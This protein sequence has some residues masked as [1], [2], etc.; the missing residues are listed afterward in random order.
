MRA[1]QVCQ[2]CAACGPDA[3]IGECGAQQSRAA[4]N[5][6]DW[7]PP[8]PDANRCLPCRS[9]SP[10]SYISKRCDGQ[11]LF[12]DRECS[13]CAPRCPAGTYLHANCSGTTY[14]PDSNDCRW[15]PGRL[16]SA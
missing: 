8:P 15:C 10:G 9:C 13:P 7:L 16:N 4:Y 11:K 2:P 14:D 6:S 12:D 5:T 3:Y 1:E